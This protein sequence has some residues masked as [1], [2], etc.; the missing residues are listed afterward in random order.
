MHFNYTPVVATIHM[1]MDRHGDFAL[2]KIQFKIVFI[3]KDRHWN[4]S[5]LKIKFKIVIMIK[6]R[7]GD[8]ANST[9]R[10]H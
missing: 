10:C 2:F 7:H 5:H 4:W 8:L 3:I 1:I 6:D 9:R